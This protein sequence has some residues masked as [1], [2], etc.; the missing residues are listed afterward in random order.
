MALSAQIPGLSQNDC[1]PEK[2]WSGGGLS[3]TADQQDRY[4]AMRESG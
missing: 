4:E 3:N 1:L 2:G